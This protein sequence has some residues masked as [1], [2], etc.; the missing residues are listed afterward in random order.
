MQNE[1]MQH[2]LF[3]RNPEGLTVAQLKGQISQWPEFDEYGNPLKVYLHW[4]TGM[5]VACCEMVPFDLSSDGEGDGHLLLLPNGGY[6]LTSVPPAE[7]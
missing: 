6:E 5:A 1:V 2:P 4:G 7:T 3:L